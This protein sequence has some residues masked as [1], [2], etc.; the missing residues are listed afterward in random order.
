M[1]VCGGGSIP[2]LQWACR[3]LV[4]IIGDKIGNQIRGM[5]LGS[6]EKRHF[7]LQIPLW[8]KK[9][10]LKHLSVQTT[11]GASARVSGAGSAWV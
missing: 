7:S 10:F 11:A 9:T 4:R 1:C 6:G 3:P 8:I 5:L 2:R